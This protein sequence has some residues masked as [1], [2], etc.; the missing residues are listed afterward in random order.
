MK[1]SKWIAAW[2][3]LSVLVLSSSANGDDDAK[4]QMDALTAQS[5]AKIS[6]TQAV[7]I[8]LKEVPEAKAFEAE[9]EMEKGVPV[10]E[11]ELLAGDAV[12]EVEINGITGKVIEVED[13]DE[14]AEE[15]AEI[16]EAL[17]AAK[18]TLGQAL[19]IAGREVKGGLAYEAELEMEDGKPVYEVELV[20]DGKFKEVEI[21]AVTGKVL[22]VEDEQAEAVLWS[23]DKDKAGKAPKG[24]SIQQTRPTETMATWQV[25][26]DKFAPSKGNVLAL[27][28]SKN[29]NG[30]YNLAIADK[31]SFKDLDVTV[32]SKAV[33]G[34]EDQ[35]GGPIW[36]C[37]D[38]DN[39]YICRFNPLESNFRVYFVKDGKRKQLASANI[40]TQPGKWYAVRARMVGNHITCHLD[41]KKLLDV[42]DDTFKDAGMVGLWTKADAVTSFDD[43]AVMKANAKKHEKHDCHKAKKEHD[44]CD[45]DGDHDDHDK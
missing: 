8:A 22:E 17:A 12:K 42:K 1:T 9:L 19:D 3:G 25:L 45:H 31:S 5:R 30:T 2:I 28:K 23:Y 38:K 21:D 13:E 39:Y 7:E 36:R 40:E 29:Y 41:G 35:G 14:E 4:E 27:T 44:D 10:Y 15:M 20:A 43:L 6:M 32:M 26:A 11:I 24:W 34:E 37:K 33:T 16:K 18:I